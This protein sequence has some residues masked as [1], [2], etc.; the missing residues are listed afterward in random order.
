MV[1]NCPVTVRNDMGW[2]LKEKQRHF[3]EWLVLT[4]QKSR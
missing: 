4:L 2:R 1:L 3:T